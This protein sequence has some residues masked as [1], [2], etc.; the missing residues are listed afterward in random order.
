MRIK[1]DRISALLVIAL[2][3]TLIA[4]FA[5]IFPY[6]F[7]FIVITLLLVFRTIAGQEKE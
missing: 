4:F 1:F 7:G 6:P 3:A 5:G 2:M